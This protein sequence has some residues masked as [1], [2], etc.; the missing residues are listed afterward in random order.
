MA[1]HGA[2]KVGKV[3]QVGE[4]GGA[5]IPPCDP[6]KPRKP[7]Q[8]VMSLSSVSLARLSPEAP[9]PRRATAGSFGYDLATIRAERIAPHETMIL[10]CGFK[11]ARDLEHDE[12]GGVAMLVFVRKNQ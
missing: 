5:T 8:P 9:L 7:G 6:G 11:L 4:V 3:S 2:G 12:G 1:G 10:P